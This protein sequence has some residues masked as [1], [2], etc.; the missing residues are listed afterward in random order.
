MVRPGMERS[1]LRLKEDKLTVDGADRLCFEP[2]G[3]FRPFR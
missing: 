3:T 2:S 1:E